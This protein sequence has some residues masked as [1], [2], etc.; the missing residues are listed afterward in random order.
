M[1]KKFVFSWQFFLAQNCF[2][3]LFWTLLAQLCSGPVSLT[4]RYNTAG[5]QQ[6]YPWSL[7]SIRFIEA[8]QYYGH[9]LNSHICSWWWQEY[10]YINHVISKGSLDYCSIQIHMI[11]SSVSF[12]PFSCFLTKNPCLFPL[13]IHV[14]ESVWI[15]NLNSCGHF[16]P[17]C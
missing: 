14:C 13:Q 7:S 2:I 17:H 4:F 15:R 10:Y 6:F 5:W 8:L 9:F 11:L 1:I 12:M 16:Y 3:Q